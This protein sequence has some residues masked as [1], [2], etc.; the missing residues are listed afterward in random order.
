MGGSAKG[1]GLAVES[2]CILPHHIGRVAK[3]KNA[4]AKVERQER[5]PQL[6]QDGDRWRERESAREKKKKA[7]GLLEWELDAIQS[8]RVLNVPMQRIM[9]EDDSSRASHRWYILSSEKTCA[10]EVRNHGMAKRSGL[11]IIS[12]RWL[13]SSGSWKL[14][15]NQKTARNS[16][17]A[18][19]GNRV[20]VTIV[21]SVV[22]MMVACRSAWP[23]G[24]V[25]RPLCC[26]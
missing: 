1:R 7:A 24:E 20:T 16:C 11:N 10:N 3:V 26:S 25:H 5:V 17:S 22:R 2:C 18:C 12:S 8:G 15:S 19:A 13:Q 6:E 21:R 4:F 9:A 14:R 23:P